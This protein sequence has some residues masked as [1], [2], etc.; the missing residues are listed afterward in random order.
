MQRFNR[1]SALPLSLFP[2]LEVSDGRI[3]FKFGTRKTVL[4]VADCDFA[5]YPAQ[6]GKLY[7]RFSGSPARTDR[8]GNGFGNFRGS[9]AWDL[10]TQSAGNQVE[11]DITLDRSNLSELTTLVEGH[12]IGVHGTV[13]SH[14]RL[15]G[16]ATALSVAGEL[17]LDDVHRWDLLPSSGEDWQIRYKGSVDLAANRLSIETAPWHASESTPV[18]VQLRVNDFITHPAWTVFAHFNQT[19]AQEILPLARRMGVALPAGLALSG[20]LNGVIGYSSNAGLNGAVAIKDVVAKVPNLS[21]LTAASASASILNDRIHFEP[22]T[23]QTSSGG[24]V[25]QVGGDFFLSP[26]QTLAAFDA[27]DF[28]LNTLKQTFADWFGTTA[29]MDALQ[30]GLVNG[31]FVYR[32]AVAASPAWSGAFQ[33]AGTSI[34]ATGLAAPLSDCSGKI[35]FDGSTV[36]LTHFTSQLGASTIH[37][38]Y[39]LNPLAKRPEHLHF[40]VNKAD[41]AQL[42]KVL[43]PTLRAQ[44]FLSRL[45]LTKRSLPDWLVGRDM[46]GEFSFD[47]FS[48][49]GTEMGPLRS[50]FSW[51]GANIQFRSLQLNL[52]EG[53]INSS[54]LLNVAGD[55]PR[56]HFNTKVT[57]FSWGGGI[58]NAEGDFDTSGTGIDTLRNLHAAGSFAGHDLNLSAE[59]GFARLS[60]LFHF[61]FAQGWP[62]LRLTNL[63]ALQGDD[64]WSGGAVSESDGKLVFD[65][66]HAG[67][68]RHIVSSFEP[69]LPSGSPAADASSVRLAVR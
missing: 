9:V 30:K 35:A 32:Q 37:A 44:G 49:E 68:Q 24:G 8:A 33:F 59:D 64:L 34:A 50:R 21:P 20:D 66:E 43:D 47:K 5:I 28:P 67:K 41:M 38:S 58:V 53:I 45:G 19:P 14:A 22:A 11:A 39:H 13:S 42:E 2:D 62:D 46:D 36:D 16:P 17:R 61:S 60:G 52:P 4:Y 54:G 7:F 6:S 3:N 48:V 56:A 25:L 31:H 51:Q 29:A 57:G 23:I 63:S 27:T 15:V 12:D 18:S 69:S 10:A 65:L 40:E 26:Q 55:V 1:P